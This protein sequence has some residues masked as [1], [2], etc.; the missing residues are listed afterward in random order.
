MVE[1]EDRNIGNYYG[2]WPTIIGLLLGMGIT[3]F[4]FALAD[5]FTS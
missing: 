4:M 2:V 3:V 5:G 1:D